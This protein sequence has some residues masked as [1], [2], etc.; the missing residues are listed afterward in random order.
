MLRQLWEFLQAAGVDWYDIALVV[1]LAAGWYWW[2][3]KSQKHPEVAARYETG[4][5]AK[6]ASAMRAAGVSEDKIAKFVA[7][8][9]VG[10]G[11]S[12]YAGLKALESKYETAVAGLKD[13]AEAQAVAMAEYAA[14]S[15]LVADLRSAMGMDKPPPPPAA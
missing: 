10:A 8:D 5:D 3:R 7:V 12:T 11:Q 9:L 13:K 6:V 4:F 14:Q 2:S 15:K 1:A